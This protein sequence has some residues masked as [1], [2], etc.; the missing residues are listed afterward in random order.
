[1]L[2]LHRSSRRCTPPLRLPAFAIALALFSGLV[3]AL[4][5]APANPPRR[6]VLFIIVDDLN[7]S[8]GCYGNSAVK[9][10]NIDRLATR[11]TRFDRAYS[12]YPLCNPSRVSLL[13]GRRP[14]TTGVYALDTAARTALPDA[15]MLPQYFRQLGYYSA[16]AG[17]VYHNARLS[18]AASW[19]FYEDGPSEDPDEK[20]AIDARYGGG[21]GRPRSQVLTSDGTRTRDGK[22]VRTI[23][24]LIEERTA[25]GQ[26]FFLAAGFH[27]PHLPWTAPR[28]FFDLYP[29]AGLIPT[30]EPTLRDVPA[31]ALQ[32]ELAGFAQ[33]DSRAEAIQG[34]Y[35]CISFTD[36][37]IGLL[38]DQLD[39]LKLWESTLV[40]L[41][42]DNG[43]HLG[44]H[45]GLWAK[46]SA[47]DAST[48]VPL[49]LAGAGVPAGRVVNQPVELLDIYPTLVALAGGNAPDGLEGS[50][51]VPLLHG[52]APGNR[53]PAT[54]LVYHYDTDRKV[55]V[56]GRT[57]IADRWRYT[58]W[59]GGAAGR[60]F[61]WRPDDPEEYHNALGDPRFAPAQ[62]SAQKMLAA[63]PTPKPGTPYRPRALIPAEPKSP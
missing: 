19:D 52:A 46:L 35:A 41:V 55:D 44:D 26:P 18:D 9:S 59:A 17:K 33:P 48:R 28:R 12:Q 61:Y 47:F 8:L 60:E 7:T 14:E 62:E 40:V 1:M 45:G 43:F 5:G 31:I 54:S 27:K 29:V 32:T 21:D 15:V 34:Y 63:L 50:S 51:L 30:A 13:S 25:A 23:A 53:R 3:P 24:R 22:N 49:L 10:P 57:V 4:G 11:G 20:A 36:E 42:G 16:G 38:I 37:H 2:S 6:N 39:R 56:V 58:E